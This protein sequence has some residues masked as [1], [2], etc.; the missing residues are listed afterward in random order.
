M[1]RS[2]LKNRMLSILPTVGPDKEKILYQKLVDNGFSE[3]LVKVGLKSF[4]AELILRLPKDLTKKIMQ[5]YPMA[6]KVQ[7][8]SSLPEQ[9]KEDLM[10]VFAEKGSASREML[11]LEFEN[12]QNDQMI[13]TRIKTQAGEIWKEYV[14]YVREV[15]SEDTEYTSELETI[16]SDWITQMKESSE[17]EAA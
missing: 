4:P 17:E 8:L 16:I 14:S 2:H 10:K 9:Q 3:E 6:K 7:L 5:D 12:I 13:Q 1:K 11:D 15:I